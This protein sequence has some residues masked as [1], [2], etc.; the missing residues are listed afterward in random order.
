MVKWREQMS[1]SSTVAAA[2][3]KE[4]RKASFLFCHF[5]KG[6]TDTMENISK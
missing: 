3:R 4:G 1:I 2:A 6:R 5:P